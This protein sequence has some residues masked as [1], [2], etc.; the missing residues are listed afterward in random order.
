MTMF[1]MNSSA[2]IKPMVLFLKAR[3]KGHWRTDPKTG[4]RVWVQ[5]HDD[6]REAAQH[7]PA[8]EGAAG[9][10]AEAGDAPA[11]SAD[12]TSL[13]EA[14]RYWQKH[15]VEGG[16]HEIAVKYRKKTYPII[17]TFERN[18]AYTKSLTN[19]GSD[20]DR[21]FDQE[22]AALMDLIWQVLR[23][24][25]SI[26]PSGKNGENKQYDKQI[27]LKGPFGRVILAPDMGKADLESGV[28]TRHRF[29][30]WHPVSGGQYRAAVNAA[31]HDLVRPTDIKKAPL[32][33]RALLPSLDPSALL[34]PGA[35]PASEGGGALNGYQP[36]QTGPRRKSCDSDGLTEST[37]KDNSA[38]APVKPSRVLFLKAY[39]HGHYRR[40]PKTGKTVW[41]ESHS[42]KRQTRQQ[43]TLFA[44]DNH[45]REH[46]R[47]N[48]AEGRVRE[49]MHSFHDL[50]H[51][52]AHKLA[53][54]LGLH[55]GRVRHA[56]KK[57]L[58]AH[59][60]GRVLDLHNELS[61]RRADQEAKATGKADIQK[62][63]EQPQESAQAAPPAP[64][65]PDP[66]DMVL[67]VAGKDVPFAYQLMEADDLAPTSG[68]AENQF[69]DRTRAASDTQVAS[70]AGNLKFRLLAD[71]PM[72]DY[73]A[74]VLADDGKTIIGG[75]GRSLAIQR[76]YGQGSAAEYRAAL[77]RRAAKFGL[78]PAKVQ[79]M[80][81]PVLVR[82]LQ[83]P[84][85]VKE[86][87]I[88]SN[89]GGGARMSA[90]EQARVDGERMGHM[91]DFMPDEDGNLNTRANEPFLRR[92]ISQFPVQQRSA[93]VGADGKLSQEGQMRLRN[94]VLYRAYGDSDVLTRMIESTDPGQRNVLAALVRAAPT[95]AQVEADAKAGHLHDLRIAPDIVAA[96]TTLAKVR[97][98]KTFGSVDDYLSQQGLFGDEISP[99]AQ[100]IL[101]HFD[102]HLRSAKAMGEF[103]RDYYDAV[104]QLGSPD[105][106]ALFGD[107]VP[108]KL[109]ILRN[110][111]EKRSESKQQSQS[112]LF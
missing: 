52:Q 67:D 105:Q 91:E 59:L 75:N 110:V 98:D 12:I 28:V 46:F 88:A 70:I 62:D 108:E 56:N 1:A 112:S 81:A 40:D 49:A 26:I 104:V 36:S 21:V 92:F 45:R 72:M 87:A 42:D 14:E 71:S 18:H 44:H 99:E 78:D 95:V 74:P 54:D 39:I 90:L 10:A 6:K 96:V 51:D 30:S 38:S 23:F 35:S 55:D 7:A 48:L 17:V 8:G 57:E 25:N 97:E 79:G 66:E 41:I 94:A 13:A 53:A 31:E 111:N 24:P 27:S 3:V 85:D 89:E 103:L 4:V 47:Q 34:A 83:Q 73:G 2:T 20:S 106:G 109:D 58:M 37:A 61:A 77:E 43:A 16:P 69:R 100:T 65:G 32:F 102:S 29:V 107:P 9:G 63:S 15:F 22:R 82:V 76:A 5:E 33:G 50:N 60:H 101:R 80:K 19:G 68:H 11:R 93:F 86:A 64:Q 84:V